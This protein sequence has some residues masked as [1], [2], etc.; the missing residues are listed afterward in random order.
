[1]LTKTLIMVLLSLIIQYLEIVD[2]PQGN[3]KIIVPSPW[4]YRRVT[5]Q[6]PYDIMGPAR[7]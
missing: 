2:T 1:M 7:T 3:R 4:G 5:V 6:C